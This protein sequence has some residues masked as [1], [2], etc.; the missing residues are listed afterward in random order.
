MKDLGGYT[1]VV[2]DCIDLVLERVADNPRVQPVLEF[3]SRSLRGQV[4]QLRTQAQTM[5]CQV[6]FSEISASKSD[7]RTYSAREPLSFGVFPEIDLRARQIGWKGKADLL[8]LSPC[9]CQIIDFKTGVPNDSHRFQIQ[10][11]A[12]LWTRDAELNPD[13]RRPERL[14]LAYAGGNLE[15][16]TPTNSELDALESDIVARREAAIEAVSLHPPEARPTPDNCRYCGVRQLCDEYW[17]ADTQRRMSRELGELRFADIEVTITGRHGPSSWDAQIELSR[18]APVGTHA[19]I[20]TNGEV[21]FRPDER[22]R[23]LNAA[24]TIGDADEEEPLVITIGTFSEIYLV[25]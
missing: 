12:L 11:Y 10:V 25:R 22:A 20:R 16:I 23:I 19:V 24:V 2:N 13:A 3:V 4:P 5:L 7:G 1:R 6:Q 14:V 21:N 17:T 8:V 15:I 9:D 18:D